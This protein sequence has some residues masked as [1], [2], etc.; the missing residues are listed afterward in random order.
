MGR[1]ILSFMPFWTERTLTSWDEI[2]AYARSERSDWLYRGQKVA[3]WELQTSLERCCDRQRV[4]A[5][6][7]LEVEAELFREFRRAYHQYARHV[8]Q[9]DAALEWRSLMQH[10]GAPSRLLDF[11]YSIYVAAYFALEAADETCAVWAVNAPWAKRQSVEAMKQAA[12]PDAAKLEDPVTEGHE[13]IIQS[14][15]FAAPF[16][17][18]ACPLNPFRLNERLRLQ[19][20]AFLV[21]GD[22]S[23]SFMD[24][25][26]AMAAHGEATNVV[27]LVIPIELRGQAL[28]QLFQMNISRTSL[29]PGLDGYARSLGIYHPVFDWVEHAS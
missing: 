8:P 16:V 21:P 25:L 29:F 19:R 14:L 27:R 18:A 13:R 10:H 15:L 6:K 24:N 9:S 5:A 3:S 2:H 4:S 17:R 7:R 28:R 26:G 1:R 12:K 23:V 20:G 11:T 22:I